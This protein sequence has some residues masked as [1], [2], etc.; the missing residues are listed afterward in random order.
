MGFNR[1]EIQKPDESGY[2]VL[3]E[4]Y[5]LSCIY[6]DGWTERLLRFEIFVD[7]YYECRGEIG[8]YSGEKD[9]KEIESLL[10]FELPTEIKKLIDLL[11]NQK[12]LQLKKY[13]SDFFME[14]SSRLHFVINRDGISHNSGIGIMLKKLENPNESE[15]LLFLLKEEFE[16]LREGLYN[17][18]L[19]ERGLIKE[20][21]TSKKKRNRRL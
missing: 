20:V 8:F 6:S 11:M 14:D 21:V 3:D 5:L 2:Y 16:K 1:L 19:L 4:E 18:M 7:I 13:Y 9:S 15:K 17:K 12:E 10:G